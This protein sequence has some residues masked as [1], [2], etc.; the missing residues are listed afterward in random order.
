[1]SGGKAPIT[2]ASSKPDAYV[3]SNNR[4]GV[5]SFAPNLQLFGVTHFTWA[6]SLDE[7]AES[8]SLDVLQVNTDGSDLV[9]TMIRK[10]SKGRADVRKKVL[11]DGEFFQETRSSVLA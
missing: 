9:V 8:T 1:M 10:E 11:H 7:A 3:A 2:R 4:D 6:I 5:L